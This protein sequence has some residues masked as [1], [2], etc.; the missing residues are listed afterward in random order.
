[1][2]NKR[3]KRRTLEVFIQDPWG[4]R[5][6][7]AYTYSLCNALAKHGLDV[8]LITNQY[9]EYDELS[10]FEIIK[11]F[12]RY[13][14]KM[15]YSK[16]R[17]MIRGIEYIMNMTRLLHIYINEKPDIIHIQWLLLYQ[18]DFFWLKILKFML[19]KSKTKLVLTAH[20][21]LPHVNGYRYRKIL[22]KIYS[23]FDAIIVHDEVLKAQ[24]YNMEAKILHLEK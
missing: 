6:P 20:N 8:R 16:F 10:N 19:R 5:G 11:I 18:F 15:K 24:M 7:G 1:M 13:S 2:H 4:I 23:Q 9:Y 21:V 17:K 14:E 12:F 3:V 22:M